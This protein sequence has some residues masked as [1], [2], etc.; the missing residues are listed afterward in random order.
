M[1]CWLVK[2][3]TSGGAGSFSATLVA[4]VTV[5]VTGVIQGTSS[6]GR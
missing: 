2:S 6:A 1:T 5:V 4:L 3:N